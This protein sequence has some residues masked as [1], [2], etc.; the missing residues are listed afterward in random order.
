LQKRKK[1]IRI[2]GN[3]RDEALD[4]AEVEESTMNHNEIV[5]RDNINKKLASLGLHL[6]LALLQVRRNESVHNYIEPMHN[7]INELP[8][9]DSIVV[10]KIKEWQ[11][12]I[13]DR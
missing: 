10:R 3:E 4:K 5:L 6:R 8:E 11:H 2:T 9:A 13:K 1:K 12:G 7:W